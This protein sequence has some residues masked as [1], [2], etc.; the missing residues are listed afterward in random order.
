M[1]CKRWLQ[2]EFWV[3]LRRRGSHFSS[4][5]RS[6][7]GLFLPAKNGIPNPK[8]TTSGS[9]ITVRRLIDHLFEA[10]IGNPQFP[11]C[12]CR[13]GELEAKNRLYPVSL[14]A[15]RG[16][17]WPRFSANRGNPWPRFHLKSSTHQPRRLRSFFFRSHPRRQPAFST[18]RYSLFPAPCSTHTAAPRSGPDWPPESPESS[19][20]PAPSPPESPS[21]RSP[22]PA[23]S[24]DGYPRLPR[25][26]ASAL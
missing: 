10:R 6:A 16:N 14:C 18:A 8:T 7:V 3:R 13:S 11:P 23:K 25:V 19:R 1:R 9:G 2:F 5:K 17:P 4:A 26:L 24:S 22:K 15:I 20:S 12:H 21:P